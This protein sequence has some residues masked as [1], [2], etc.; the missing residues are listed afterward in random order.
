M[1]IGGIL[2]VIAVNVSNIQDDHNVNY[3]K[4]LY[5]YI[6]KARKSYIPSLMVVIFYGLV[7]EEIITAFQH[8]SNVFLSKAVL[9]VYIISFLVGMGMQFGL[10]KYV[11]QKV[12]DFLKK[13]A[14]DKG[15]ENDKNEA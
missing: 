12:D 13:W 11:F 7:H 14:G 9:M 15:K 8:S 1:G 2:F 4:V 6:K 5:M 10:Y 3:F